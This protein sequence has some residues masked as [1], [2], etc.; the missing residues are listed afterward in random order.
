MGVRA[1]RQQYRNL[2]IATCVDLLQRAAKAYEAGSVTSLAE[3]LK[4]I[5]E[6]VLF[7]WKNSVDAFLEHRTEFLAIG[8]AATAAVL[9]GFENPWQLFR[10]DDQNWLLYLYNNLNT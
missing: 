6:S 8:K 2:L 4:K 10:Y 9:V 1:S 3:P 5:T 7:L